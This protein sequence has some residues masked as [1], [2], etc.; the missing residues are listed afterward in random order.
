MLTSVTQTAI[1]DGKLQEALDEVNS[2]SILTIVESSA[3]PTLSPTEPPT[4]SSSSSLS[5]GAI[6]GIV[7]GG[8]VI[9]SSACVSLYFSHKSHT[10]T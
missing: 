10:C 6:V 1:N 9:V 2:N 5:T 7:L 3:A 8:A 4:T